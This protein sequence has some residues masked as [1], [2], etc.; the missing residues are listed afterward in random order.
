MST[1]SIS[2]IVLLI[3]GGA[4]MSAEVEKNYFY[5]NEVSSLTPLIA[6]GTQKICGVRFNGMISS[7]I[8][9]CENRLCQA[10]IE[11]EQSMPTADVYLTNDFALLFSREAI[12][13]RDSADVK[14][15]HHTL[16]GGLAVT[17][18]IST[19]NLPLVADPK[20]LELMNSCFR[21]VATLLN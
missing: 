1:R 17:M 21:R 5:D 10:K 7:L 20:S 6:E 2:C 3:A 14:T 8:M 19:R 13:R 4:A 11:Y 18:S 9:K 15:E 12:S 16:Q